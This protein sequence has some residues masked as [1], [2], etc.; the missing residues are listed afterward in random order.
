VSESGQYLRPVFPLS[1]EVVNSARPLVRWK[2][3]SSSKATRID[4][5]RDR[6]CSSILSTV[7]TDGVEA[8]PETDLPLGCVFWRLTELDGAAPLS[9]PTQ[10][11]E[12]WIHGGPVSRTT[13]W[14]TR[15]DINGDGLAD[16]VTAGRIVF[17]TRGG[18][19]SAHV[20]QVD[21]TRLAVVGDVN[22]DGVGD[23][24]A[25]S[26]G[27][28]VPPDSVK[29]KAYLG[30]SSGL[31]DRSLAV[32][33]K[34]GT[35]GFYSIRPAGDVN[36]D[37]FADFAI[38]LRYGTVMV[39]GGATAL[40]YDPSSAVGFLGASTAL[41]GD[42]NGDGLS[43]FVP[44]PPRAPDE[45][46]LPLA[47]ILADLTAD[48]F[49][50]LVMRT[51]PSG[52]NISLFGGSLDGLA[53]TPI[54]QAPLPGLGVGLGLAASGNV[55]GLA[56]EDAVAAARDQ[57][58]VFPQGFSTPAITVATPTGM[59]HVVNILLVGDVDGDG[60][61]DITWSVDGLTAVDFGPITDRGPRA[62]TVVQ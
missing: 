28:V 47:G 18:D 23:V 45:S 59:G 30:D 5:C 49:A 2:P 20:Q 55:R 58:V 32:T 25:Y 51:G 48:G 52:E 15:P 9:A 54:F 12:V 8:K 7:V 43:D 31:S 1:G 22:G 60:I 34:T 46:P 24:I 29:F 4:F 62:R 3:S 13:A 39:F 57:Y 37:G 27:D 10:P 38:E 16:I 36:G 33:I 44:P 6:A 14:G 26:E 21:A 11:W 53:P 19:L 42:V 40:T 50:D 61:D 35:L 17:G 41:D 56:A